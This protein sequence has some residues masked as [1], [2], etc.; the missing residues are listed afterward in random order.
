[1][2][3]LTVFFFSSRRR[4]TKC[5]LVTGVQTWA[6]PICE[7]LAALGEVLGTVDRIDDPHRGIALQQPEQ[8]GVT[9]DPLL[10]DQ[11]RAR[12]QRRKARG[13]RALGRLVGDCPEVVG[14]RKS[15]VSGKSVSVRVNLGGGRNLK[16]KTKTKINPPYIKD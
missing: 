9:F 2:S 5:A 7:A 14:D 3:V 8:A 13:E 10:A 6:L 1:M 11:H 16:K 4:H 12:H 15:G